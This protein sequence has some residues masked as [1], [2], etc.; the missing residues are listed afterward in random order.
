MGNRRDGFSQL[1]QC[2]KV[3]DGKVTL[4][5][6]YWDMGSM[7]AQAP[8]TWLEPFDSRYVLDI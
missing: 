7:T 2:D 5:K 3:E 8:A 1:R 6:D 4:W